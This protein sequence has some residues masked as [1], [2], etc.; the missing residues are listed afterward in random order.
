MED[1]HKKLP[2]GRI[3]FSAGGFAVGGEGFFSSGGE[4][5]KYKIPKVITKRTEDIQ[6]TRR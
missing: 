5:Y 1:K 2:V 4:T 6:V 3:S